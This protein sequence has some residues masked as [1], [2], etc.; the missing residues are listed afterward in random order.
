MFRTND[1]PRY[2]KAWTSHLV[3]YAVQLAALVVVRVLLVRRNRAKRADAGDRVQNG[4]GEE[5]GRRVAAERREG[6][7]GKAFADL[8]D[9][10]NPECEW[11]AFF[12][13]LS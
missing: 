11:R 7:V 8:T 12:P 13:F 4:S 9:W 5:E 1:G 10:E 6:G 3:V 2:L